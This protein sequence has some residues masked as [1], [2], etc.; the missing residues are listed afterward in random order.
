MQGLVV[1]LGVALILYKGKSVGVRF[2]WRKASSSNKALP[3]EFTR[4]LETWQ[5]VSQAAVGGS[6][7]ATSKPARERA[8]NVFFNFN[9]H[10]WEAYEALGLPAGSSVEQAEKAY[11]LATSAPNS[12]SNDFFK[13]A[14]EAI[15][16]N[17]KP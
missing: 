10:S 6:V 9:G 16:Q 5:G 4:P 11:Q 17:A 1:L 7:G 3:N 15:R 8:L 12:S 13:Q 2:N 14:L